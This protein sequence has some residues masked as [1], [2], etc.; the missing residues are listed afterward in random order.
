VASAASF[1]G[2]SEASEPQ[3]CNCTSGN[4]EIPGSRFARPGMTGWEKSAWLGTVN[5]L[6]PNVRNPAKLR[7][8]RFVA[9]CLDFWG[10]TAMVCATFEKF[11]Q[12]YA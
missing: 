6:S 9:L 7:I 1:R 2:V 10:M 3:M 4:L 8:Q 12:P 5:L 11:E